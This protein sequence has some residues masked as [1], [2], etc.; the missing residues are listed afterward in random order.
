[1]RKALIP[2]VVSVGLIAI[3][4]SPANAASTRA[5]YIA[6]VDPICQS[7]VGPENA[8]A[9]AYHRNYKRM[10]HDASSGTLKRWVKQTRRTV[11]SLTRWD[12]IHSNMTE[13]IAA[14]PPRTPMQG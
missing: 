12:Q 1:M 13:Q 3:W 2:F 6:Q 10:I 9:K 5:E 8:A 7:F 4:A 11:G 14:V